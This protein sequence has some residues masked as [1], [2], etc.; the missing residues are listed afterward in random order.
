VHWTRFFL[1]AVLS[2]AA[3]S[4]TDWIFMGML[5]HKNYFETPETWRDKPGQ[6]ETKKI[7]VSAILGTVGCAAFIYLCYWTGALIAYRTAVRMA[8][9]VW[10]AAP[11]PV[12]LT[13]VLWIKINPLIG[14]SH[15]LGWL[16]RFLVTA[17]LA[18]WLLH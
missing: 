17:L 12:I 8:A 14:L 18:V 11:V 16:V 5:F 10:I 15:S 1:A 13:N 2:G 7:V 4:M 6:A 3:A 9:V